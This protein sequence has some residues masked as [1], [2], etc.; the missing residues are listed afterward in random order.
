ML[1]NA[2]FVGILAVGMTLVLISGEVDL[3]IGGNIG[4]T[5]VVFAYTFTSGFNIWLCFILAISVGIIIGLINIF[6]VA[7]LRMNSLI[8]TLGTLAV[9]QGLAFT[10][11]DGLGIVVMDEKLLKLTYGD[12]WK[13]PI[14]VIILVISIVIM[15]LL[16]N[17][18]KFGR[19]VKVVGS[20][21]T[22]AYLC[23]LNVVKIKSICLFTNAMIASFVGLLITANAAS[24]M[25]QNGRNIEMEVLAVVILGGASL[26]G[27]EGSILGTAFSI[28]ILSVLYNGLTVANVPSEIVNMLKGFVLLLIVGIYATREVRTA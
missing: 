20:N 1:R 25:P 21:R 23:G 22:V 14:P 17:F 24:G 9:A 2:S 13:I 8:T 15:G 10:I 6:F 7:Y 11:T 3:S 5:S 18:T 4:L 16:L 12:L 26:K 28:L 27:G 19:V